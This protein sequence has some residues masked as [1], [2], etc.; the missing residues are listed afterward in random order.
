MGNGQLAHNAEDNSLVTR[1]RGDGGFRPHL[2]QVV[3]TSTTK[4]SLLL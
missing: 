4:R 2:S 3:I 1:F